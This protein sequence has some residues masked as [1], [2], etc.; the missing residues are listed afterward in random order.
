[1]T[2]PNEA[3]HAGR[4]TDSPSFSHSWLGRSFLFLAT[5]VE[6]RYIS[7][8]FA[9]AIAALSLRLWELTGRTM[10]YDEAIHLYYSWRLANLEGFV[11]SP[12]MHGPFQI[13]LVALFL[14]LFGDTDFAARLGYALFG[15]VLVVLPFFLRDYLGRA[16]AMLTGVML[17]ISPSLL[18]FSRFGRNDIIMAVLAAST[19]RDRVPPAMVSSMQPSTR[20]ASVTVG[21]VPPSP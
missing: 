3:H 11:H 20:L 18:Y 1:M 13:E 21:S 19:S 16:G 14:R 8:F 15:T 6:G 4:Q 12:W 10:H 2:T 9:I 7:G 17:A 5:T